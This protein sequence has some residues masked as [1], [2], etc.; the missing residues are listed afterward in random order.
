MRKLNVLGFSLV[1]M[2]L[3]I[4]VIGILAGL[5]VYVTVGR[6]TER[7]K[8]NAAISDLT[9][10]GQ[11][12]KIYLTNNNDYPAEVGSGIKPTSPEDFGKYLSNNGNWPTGP[13]PDSEYDYDKTT[14]GIMVHL[15]FCVSGGS[16]QRPSSTWAN[17]VNNDGTMY[18]CVKE[19]SPGGCKSLTTT[20]ADTSEPGICVGGNKSGCSV[21]TFQ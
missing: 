12:M 18:Y 11:A 9:Q 6:S 1:E 17:D 2:T 21:P 16:C 8:F 13:W 7:S 4:T 15:R 5:A 3:V 20:K 14:E 10:I 19:I